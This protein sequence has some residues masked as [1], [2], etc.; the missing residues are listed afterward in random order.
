MSESKN[1][2]RP[3]AV[4]FTDPTLTRGSF[5]DE[6][7]VS[8]IVK[9]YARTGMVNHVARRQPQ[10]FAAPELDFAEHMRTQAAI[11]TYSEE[12]QANPAGEGRPDP[13]KPESAAER[14][15][16]ELESVSEGTDENA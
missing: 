5:K 11:A 8:N 13:K 3:H 7:D 14:A 1:I 16:G 10:Y 2:T 15:T 4:V 6:C 9:T 12:S